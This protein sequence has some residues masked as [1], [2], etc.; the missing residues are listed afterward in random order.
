MDV[1]DFG[2]ISLVCGI[3]REIFEFLGVELP[4]R[5]ILKEFLNVML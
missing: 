2:T 1:N 4:N 3:L 5:K